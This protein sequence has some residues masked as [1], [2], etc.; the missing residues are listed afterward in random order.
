ME[1]AVTVG[2]Y[3]GKSIKLLSKEELLYFSKIEPARILWQILFEWGSI[4]LAIY[5]C[6]TYW[7]PLLYLITVMWIGARQHALGGLL[8]E[9]AHFH[10]SR[11]KKWNDLLSEV[12]LAWPIFANLQNFRNIH[13]RHHSHLNSPKDPDWVVKQTEEWQFPKS[14]LA[15][16]GMLLKH[17]LGGTLIRLFKQNAQFSIKGKR[18]KDIIYLFKRS[19]FY[20]LVIFFIWYFGVFKEF[21]LYW[22][23]PLATWLSFIFHI[24]A[25]GEHWAI[26]HKEGALGGSRTILLSKFEELFVTPHNFNYHAEHHL[27]PSVPYYRLKKLHNFL[28][29]K[30]QF[31]NQVHLTKGY[32][33][34]FKE[35]LG[36]ELK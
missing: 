31:R 27:Y 18:K 23:V 9:G 24:R 28:M 26:D 33:G 4:I 25:I 6:Q 2:E 21:L 12:V 14:K 11:K 3:E 15:L 13:L 5:L 29:Q 35:C 30:P 1:T 22:I 32:W 16:I 20:L 17:L 19:A 10:I 8:H 34:L 36:K 7:H